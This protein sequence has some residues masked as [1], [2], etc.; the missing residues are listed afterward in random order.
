M[1]TDELNRMAEPG[2]IFH[3]KADINCDTASDFGEFECDGRTLAEQKEARR[4]FA[5]QYGLDSFLRTADT[6]G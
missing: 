6:D 4:L 1:L 3:A 2:Y 5:E